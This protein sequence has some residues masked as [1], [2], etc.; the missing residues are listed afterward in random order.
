MLLSRNSIDSS[1]GS[2][3][4]IDGEAFPLE[5]QFVYRRS[6]LCPN[7]L[8]SGCASGHRRLGGGG[9]SGGGAAA[10][11]C[12]HF[13]QCDPLLRSTDAGA[14]VLAVLFTIEEDGYEADSAASQ[15]LDS[16]AQ[17]ASAVV[18]P[19]TTHLLGGGAP[20]SL[21]VLLPSDWSEDYIAYAGSTT[22]PPCAESVTWVVAASPMV[23]KES[24]L[25][26]IRNTHMKP[27]KGTCMWL[28]L[29]LVSV[30]AE[31][32][33]ASLLFDDFYFALRMC[34]CMY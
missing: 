17:A 6:G 24:Q 16:I 12:C 11:S 3:H 20:V 19:Q 28:L 1:K 2:E 14:A 18:A 27:G 15:V 10:A 4:T 33:L 5:M 26:A 32:L 31:L 29:S 8:D 9:G 30:I 21:S 7:E 13:E 22:S 34:V 25:D 23:I